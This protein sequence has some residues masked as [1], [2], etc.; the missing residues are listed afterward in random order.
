MTCDHIEAAASLIRGASGNTVLFSGAGMSEESGIPTYRSG[1]A[2]SDLPPPPAISRRGGLAHAFLFQFARLQPFLIEIGRRFLRAEP[3]PGHH[4]IA[5]MEARKEIRAVITQ[6]VDNLHQVAGSRHVIELHGNYFRT[7]CGACAE[8]RPVDRAVLTALIDRLA[9]EGRSRL[10]FWR[11]FKRYGP[12]CARC[13]R[14]GRPDMVMFGEPLSERDYVAAEELAAQCKVMLVVGTTALVRP[15]N[16]LP[17]I[18]EHEGASVV[19]IN[20]EA[21]DVT[22]I[23]E[24]SIRGRASEV[25]PRLVAALDATR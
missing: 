24:I 15:A 1:H 3:N 11:T 23:A 6:N 19:E 2:P 25:L 10:G 17:W 20:P 22:D 7:R 12:R 4:A 9:R 18:A 16:A 8:A 14:L 21:T 13:G 5:R